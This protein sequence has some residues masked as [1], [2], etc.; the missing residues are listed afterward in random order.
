M[1]NSQEHAFGLHKLLMCGIDG[2]FYAAAG[3][4]QEYGTEILMY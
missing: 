4:I 1:K 2:G 3:E